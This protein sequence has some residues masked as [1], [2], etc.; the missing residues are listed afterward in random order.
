MSFS[1]DFDAPTGTY[2]NHKLSNKLLFT[3]LENSVMMPFVDTQEDFGKRQ[4]ESVT[5][6]RF[7]HITEPADATLSE[8]SPIPEVAFD[9]TTH[10]ITVTENGLAVPFTGKLEA[11]SKFD[12]ESAV[13]RTL[14]EQMRLVLDSRGYTAAKAINIKYAPTSS[15]AG[16]FNF[17]GTPTGTAVEDLAYFHI[18]DISQRMFDSLLIPHHSN[19][20]YIGIFRHKTLQTLR[21]D[22]QFLSWNQFSSPEKKAKG[23]TGTIEQI[24]LISTNHSATGALPNAGSNN[25]GTGIVFGQDAVVMAEAESP[26]LRAGIPT[27]YGRN[28]GIAWYGI[29]GFGLAFDVT[30]IT[31]EATSVG[32]SRIVHV[33]SA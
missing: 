19:D 15:T 7:Q 6:T 20:Q 4:G 25:F 1:W 3:A 24:R 8:L 26:H 29:Y 21:R 32:I 13:Q 9:L 18:E 5:I 27:D 30:G 17:A 28:K 10:A 11:L 23:E 22:G 16:T 2:K 12:I 14:T 31:T 33:T